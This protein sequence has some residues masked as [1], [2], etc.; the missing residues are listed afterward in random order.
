[1]TGEQ[2]RADFNATFAPYVLHYPSVSIHFDGTP[3]DPKNSIER[4]HDFSTKPIVGKTRVINDLSLKVIEWKNKVS[5]RRI[6]FG[7]ETGVVLGTIPANITA[8]DYSFSVYAYAPFFQEMA[9][10]NLLE[11]DELGDPDFV[12]VVEY[13]RD[14]V[15]DYF[16]DR[17]AEKSSELIQALKEAGVYPYEGDPKDEIE[18]RERQ[19]FDIATHA[20]QSYSRDFKKAENA[21]KKITLGLLKEALAH[22]PESVTRILKAVFN[23][24]KNK[25]DDFSDLLERTQLSHIISASS[26]IA[27]RVVTLKVLREMVFD[28]KHRSTI[29]ERGELD[30]LVGENTWIFGENFHFT[31][32]ESGL[33]KIMGRVS[34]EIGKPRS[35]NAKARKP[36]G[37]VGRI[38]S[39]MGRMVPNSNPSHREFLLVERTHPRRAALLRSEANWMFC[40]YGRQY[41]QCEKRGFNDREAAAR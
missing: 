35:R 2:A 10:K 9:D 33:T 40:L 23:L 31:M 14:Q 1:M 11:L 20:V 12:R 32:Q 37:K 25:Q 24:P 7:G 38:D 22:N 39:F 18:R 16:R 3:V 36:D 5:N 21:L 19:V 4:F 6:H 13:I 8:P 41:R 34:D 27:G 26:L 17:E 29:K 30:V 15:G 28:P